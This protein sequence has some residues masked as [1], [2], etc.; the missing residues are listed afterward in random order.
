M[1]VPTHIYFCKGPHE[2]S[3]LGRSCRPDQ[4]LASP[5]ECECEFNL[6]KRLSR[7]GLPSW[8][9]RIPLLLLLLV[10]VNGWSSASLLSDCAGAL[11]SPSRLPFGA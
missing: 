1:Y 10:V 6:L 3:G 8:T 5:C 9:S 7:S 11:T 2:V 4:W